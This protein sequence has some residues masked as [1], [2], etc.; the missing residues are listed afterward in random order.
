MAFVTGLLLI[1]AP[2]SALNNLGNIPGE[3][4]E[5]T[6]GVKVISTK[7]GNFPYVSAQAFRYWLRMTL[8]QRVPEWKASPIFREE[9]IAYTDATRSGIGTM[10]FSGTCGRPAKLTLPN[11]VVS[12]SVRLKNQH[13]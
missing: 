6:V 8:E 11:G 12:K 2:A 1:D 7:A 10:T 13:R 4:E 9:K 5:N 3:R